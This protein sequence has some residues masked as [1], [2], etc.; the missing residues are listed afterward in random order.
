VLVGASRGRETTPPHPR[1]C[2]I[3]LGLMPFRGENALVRVAVTR[4]APDGGLESRFSR[5]FLLTVITLYWVTGIISS[6]RDYYDNRRSRGEPRLG[7]SDH[8]YVP[9]AVAVFR[10]CSSPR[11][12]HRGNGP[13]GSTTSTAGPS[14]PAAGTAPRRRTPACRPRHRGH[15]SAPW[16]GRPHQARI[17]RESVLARAERPVMSGTNAVPAHRGR[18]AERRFMCVKPDGRS[19]RV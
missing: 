2:R 4:I 9:P 11:P 15:S 12:S 14:C 3:D 7:P 10:T 5:D 16:T 6:I 13:N 8:I 1:T 19:H 17:D 18:S